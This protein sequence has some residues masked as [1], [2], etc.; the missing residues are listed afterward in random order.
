MFAIEK[1]SYV[2]PNGYVFRTNQ[3]LFRAIRST[4]EPF[5]RDFLAKG[6]AARLVTAGLLIDTHIA[7]GAVGP[8]EEGLVLQHREIRPLTYCVEWSP[9]MLRD[10]ALVT[11]DLAD[12]LIDED[13]TLQDAYPWNVL[14][15]GA[16]PI[17]V[18]FTSIVRAD[19][20]LIWPAY[21]Q[22][23][24]FFLRPLHLAAM[25][26]GEMARALLTESVGGISRETFLRYARL[27]S[28]LR[29]PGWDIGA[30]ADR[31]IQSRPA[32]KTRIHELA[33]TGAARPTPALRRRFF[34]GLRRQLNAFRFRAAGEIWERYYREIPGWVDRKA[35]L[36][37]LRAILAGLSP[38]SVLDLG[39]N[40]GTF[41][42]IA[43]E[44]GAR[45][46]SVDSSEACIEA[47]YREARARKLPVTP[48]IGDVL[49][50]TPALGFMAEQFPPFIQRAK[51]DTVLC[52]GLM[53]H[54]HVAGRQPIAAIAEMLAR[55]AERALVFEFVAMDDANVERIE[56][57]RTLDYTLES[58]LAAL[59]RHFPTI[60][61]LP[62]DRDT[63]RLLV[64]R[65]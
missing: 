19:E 52:L 24:S 8:V 41:S 57:N 7:S 58:V 59:Q 16:A 6:A 43:A 38:Q 54:L 40:T 23:Q 10:A 17:H 45:V 35:K 3:G 25:R 37:A 47:L 11:V 20:R 34:G 60:E 2:D 22:F 56:S 48:V 5:Y 62:S 18:D 15:D 42:I 4:S 28:R 64:C 30:A 1:S 39:C 21:A 12:T 49:T 33:R 55:L 44:G 61:A 51:S 65:K 36:D 14:F 50:P 26:R 53:H 46:L 32:L 9:S 63:R 29:H 27:S 31:L 13:C